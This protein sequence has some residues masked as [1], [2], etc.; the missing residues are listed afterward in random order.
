MKDGANKSGT[1][2]W[3]YLRFEDS[4]NI[5]H[6][7]YAFGGL[8]NSINLNP[9]ETFNAGDKIYLVSKNLSATASEYCT[10]LSGTLT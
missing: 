1:V 8:G 10:T 6:Q 9:Y 5:I 3:D 4:I 2:Y 7:L